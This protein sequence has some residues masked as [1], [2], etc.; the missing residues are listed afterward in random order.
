MDSSFNVTEHV[1]QAQYIRE[2]P[3]TTYPQDAPVK[4]R[5]KKYTP[6]SNQNPQE[7][8][9]TIIGAHGVG[10]LKELYEPLWDDLLARSKK[11]GF[12]IRAIW[13][14]DCA[15]QGASGVQNENI[16]GN[17]TSWFDHARDLL[18]M[19]NHFREDMPRPIMGVGHSAGG[20]QL[21]LLS[22]MHPRLFSSLTLLDPYLIPDNRDVNALTLFY[23]TATRRDIWSSRK[24]AERFIRRALRSWDPRVLDRWVHYGFRNL[25]T[26]I[27]PEVNKDNGDDEV[28]VTLTTTK[29]QEAFTLA[30]ANL[31]G[32]TQLGL[33]ESKTAADNPEMVGKPH[34]ALFLP[35]ILGPLLDGQKFYRPDSVLAY[36]LLPHLR[37]GALFVSGAESGLYEKGH[38]S[39]AVKMAG[40]GFS[41]SGGQRYSRIKH[42]V[43]DKGSHTFPMEMVTQTASYIGP[44]I[45]A[46]S[47]RWRRDEQRIAAGWEGL[48]VK[49]RSTIPE[50][51]KAPL[52]IWKPVDKRS[53][54][55]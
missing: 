28:P 45:A 24:E 30:R 16:M 1:I 4:L 47:E 29:H 39:E 32:Q 50:D 23:L 14:A 3:R 54:K 9:I 25:P 48:S 22:L 53:A 18:H 15:N 36:R 55:L 27:Y 42:I 17:E 11:D 26:A 49:E 40:T 33:S 6:K 52:S 5:I 20:S 41:G 34:D 31:D 8:D 2:Y 12:R 21:I 44:W 51:W 19:I 37:P 7:G 38:Q 43:M 13:I 35:D 46:E 10:F